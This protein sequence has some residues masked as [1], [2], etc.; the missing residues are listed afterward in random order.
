MD[1]IMPKGYLIDASVKMSIQREAISSMGG[2]SVFVEGMRRYDIFLVYRCLDEAFSAAFLDM[3][4]PNCRLVESNYA[5][6]IGGIFTMYL[7]YVSFQDVDMATIPKI[8]VEGEANDDCPKDNASKL[9]IAKI[10]EVAPEFIHPFQYLD[11]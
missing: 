9:D 2:S 1:R 5:V 7:Q 10:E 3:L 6:D 4:L 8:I 11:V